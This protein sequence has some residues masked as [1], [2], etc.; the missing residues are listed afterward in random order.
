M[1]NILFAAVA[2]LSLASATAA[3]AQE[4]TNGFGSDDQQQNQQA[5]SSYLNNQSVQAE[6]SDP[7][8]PD[9]IRSHGHP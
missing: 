6:D 9:S 1:R 5:V 8:A 2:V 3:V 7:T 4:D